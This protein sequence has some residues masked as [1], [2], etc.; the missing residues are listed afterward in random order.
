MVSINTGL[1]SSCFTIIFSDI[2][3]F[4][5]FGKTFHLGKC[6]KWVPQETD[7]EICMQWFWGILSLGRIPEKNEGSST[8]QNKLNY[9][10]CD[11]SMTFRVGPRDQGSPLPC[12]P[13]SHV[14][15][16][17]I[18]CRLL[19]GVRTFG[20]DSLWLRAIWQFLER[21]S[22]ETAHTPSIWWNNGSVLKGDLGK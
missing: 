16:I 12:T 10:F 9:E 2:S 5:T 6:C 13:Y 17:D 1:C 7:S 15:S 14:P 8:G 21:D 19:S 11:P 20:Q 4:L 18:G 3:D 22:T